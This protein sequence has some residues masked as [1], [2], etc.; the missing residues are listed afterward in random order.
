MLKR[1]FEVFTENKREITIITSKEFGEVAYVEVGAL[2]VG[3]IHQTFSPGSY[4]KK[5][6]E[7]GFLL[8]EDRLLF[9]YFS[10]NGLS[11][12]QI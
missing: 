10:P 4:V 3:S 5:G 1:N 8:L 12:M 11:L 7:K 2:N 9:Y 6:A